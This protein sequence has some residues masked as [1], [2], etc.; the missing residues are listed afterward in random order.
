M[1]AVGRAPAGDDAMKEKL[2]LLFTSDYALQHLLPALLIAAAA[3][4]AGYYVGRLVRTLVR[5]LPHADEA[6]RRFS[7]GASSWS[8]WLFGLVAALN[9]LGV[10]TNGILAAFGG[11]AIA[12][13]LALKDT[14]GNVAAGLELVFLRPLAVGDFIAFRDPSDIR[15]AGTVTRIGLFSTELR[16]PDG[17]FLSVP[18]RTLRDEPLLNFDRNPERQIRLVFGV[19]YSD[20]L[21]AG[22]RALLELGT[23][24]P[25]RVPDKPVEVFVDGL[26]DSAVNLSLRVW[27]GKADY[28]PARRDLTKAGKAALE[29]AGLVIPFPQRDVH[30]IR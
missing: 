29:A 6:V 13:G 30:L 22:L 20:S 25:R 21:D 9:A 2:R 28:W 10:N 17:L 14:L 16:T 12:V 7:G 4:V 1:R 27:V 18:N 11:L 15:A 3:A 23:A 26:A 19:S 8:V 5:R 24:E